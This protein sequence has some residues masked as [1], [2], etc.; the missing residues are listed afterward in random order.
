MKNNK[1]F[2]YVIIGTGIISSVAYK[3]LL[4]RNYNIKVINIDKLPGLQNEKDN[5]F[6]FK[7][8]TMFYGKGG[9]SNI[10][11][12]T[13][14]LYPNNYLPLFLSKILSNENMRLVEN[15]L[16]Y[17]QVPFN[18]IQNVSA[19]KKD[20]FMS[21]I[22][23]VEVNFAIRNKELFNF[24]E[25]FKKKDIWDVDLNNIKI[26]HSEQKIEDQISNQKIYY[27]TLLLAAGGIGNSFLINK[28]FKNNKNNGKN[29]MNHLKFSPLVF[30]TSKRLRINRVTGINKLGNYEIIP[31][32]FIKDE[33]EKLLHSY[34]IYTSL[35]TELEKNINYLYLIIDKIFR[36]LGFSKYFKILVYTDMKPGK[37]YLEFTGDE[38]ILN[39]TED[40]TIENI[41]D[42]INAINCNLRKHPKVKK[43]VN[44]VNF[45][46]NEGSHHIGTTIMGE[47]ADNSVVDLNSDLYGY[48]NIKVFGT[49]VL[50]RAGSGHP[51]LTAMV[52][53][54]LELEKNSN[55]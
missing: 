2:D 19:G 36:K 6:D 53:T 27:K 30:E 15:I 24:Y 50:P 23:D 37:N 21:D 11:S 43:I 1:V 55:D 20:Y 13:Y 28:Y 34:R 52:L 3:T 10:W 51:T 38:I 16:K 45:E 8:G 40:T 47:H 26:D 54:I 12:S 39:T 7:K 32:Y 5:K 25:V 17:F 33:D 9:T 22:N 44:K 42:S 49:S 29:Y 35:R 18:E 46:I 4:N 31:T 14:D 48:K 41:S